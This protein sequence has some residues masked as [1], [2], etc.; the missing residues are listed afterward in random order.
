M[1]VMGRRVAILGH[2]AAAL[3]IA[4]VPAVGA[5]FRSTAD[6]ATVFYDAPSNKA[7]P[8]FVVSRG[9]PVEIMVTLSGWTK[10]R[11]ADGSIV[12]VDERA[13]TPKRTV[14]VK[15]RVAEVRA[16]PDDFARVAFKVAQGVLLELVEVMP[17]GW[18]RIRHAD[19]GTGFVRADDI[20]GT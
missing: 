11:D 20:W 17:S 16:A 19:G 3:I 1:A 13:L 2:F 12:W 4:A 18:I 15:S 8:L 5:E 14:V 7:R 10:V 9:Y 6:T